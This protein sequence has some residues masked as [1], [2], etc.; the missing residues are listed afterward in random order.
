MVITSALAALVMII[1]AVAGL[2]PIGNLFFW[3]SSITA[4][5]VIV[6]EILVSIAVIVY[7]RRVGGG[8]L[9]KTVIAPAISTV[10]LALGLYLVMSRFNLLAGTVPDGVDPSLPESA[11]LLNPL[12]WF[13]VLLPFIFLGVGYVA[14]LI[15]KKENEQLVKDFAS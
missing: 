12:G 2:D 14:A 1:F 7:F 8:N 15:N 6:V 9:W 5:S 13:L 4:I 11:W 3:M 10:L